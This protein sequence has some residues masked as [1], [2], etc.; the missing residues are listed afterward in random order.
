MK[1]LF[2][3][4]ITAEMFRNG[5]LESIEA[6]MAEGEIKDIE[7]SPWIPISE[8]APEKDV[9]VLATTRWGEI[10]IA[11]MFS[12]NNWFIHEGATNAE[13]DEIVAWMPLP[14]PFKP[15]P[16]ERT[17]ERAETHECDYISREALDNAISGLTYWHFEN[18]RLIPGGGG[19]KTETVYKVD[20]V[21]RLTHILPSVTPQPKTEG[22]RDEKVGHWIDPQQDDGMSDPIYYQ[23]RCSECNFDLDPQTWAQELHQ[24]GADKYCPRC[25]CRMQEVKNEHI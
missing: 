13:I 14:A 4:E 17:E 24:Y 7:Y 6:L 19:I 12:A 22:A 21:W 1:G 8:R 16:S 5:C 25:G 23:V 18:G 15:Q 10:T 9:E 2:I 20:D 3:P 11:E